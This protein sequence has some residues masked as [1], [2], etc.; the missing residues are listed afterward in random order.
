VNPRGLNRCSRGTSGSGDSVS[1][2]RRILMSAKA[3]LSASW[4]NTAIAKATFIFGYK[5]LIALT[6]LGEH[7]VLYYN[8]KRVPK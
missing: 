4:A 6:S 1:L 3:S 7:Q 5:F 8:F 2:P